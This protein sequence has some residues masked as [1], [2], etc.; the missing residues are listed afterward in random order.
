[1]KEQ[2]RLYLDCTRV[3]IEQLV[4]VG[5]VSK[6]LEVLESE[7]N[8]CKNNFYY[9][10]CSEDLFAADFSSMMS[11]MNVHMFG[12]L[13]QVDA[14]Y[15]QTVV[16]FVEHNLCGQ[17]R[18]KLTREQ[19]F[20]FNLMCS[21]FK[22]DLNRL[23]GIYMQTFRL[24]EHI[25]YDIE[26]VAKYRVRSRLQV[27]LDKLRENNYV[28]ISFKTKSVVR[29]NTSRSRTTT[30]TA[31]AIPFMLFIPQEYIKVKLSILY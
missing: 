9:V 30:E 19:F 14:N 10:S 5:Q 11:S 13:K 15:K 8:F 28:K 18:H 27:V 24:C 4:E 29:Q 6:A 3:W 22:A 12:M 21:E 31:V 17:E 2:I 26:I 7:W 20:R 1:L 16:H 23:S 25:I